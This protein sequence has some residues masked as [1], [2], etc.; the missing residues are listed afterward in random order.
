MEKDGEGWRRMEKGQQVDKE[1]R[2]TKKD[3]V[4]EGWGCSR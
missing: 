3:E 4:G 1:R 2:G